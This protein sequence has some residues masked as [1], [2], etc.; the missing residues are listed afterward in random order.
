[1][2]KTNQFIIIVILSIPGIVISYIIF[3]LFESI[4]ISDEC[5][6]HSEDASWFIEL[7][8]DFPSWNGC[9]P[10]PS[11]F[12]FG[13]IFTFGIFLSYYTTNKL[14]SKNRK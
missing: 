8:Y 13:L 5:K 9:H 6:Y 2:S 10:W 11:N 14:I 1:L 7:M 3:Y 12:Q 4:L